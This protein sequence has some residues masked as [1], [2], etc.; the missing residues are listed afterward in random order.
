M[1]M[2]KNI[3]RSLAGSVLMLIACC[4][5]PGKGG[6]V[7]P[8]PPPPQENVFVNP[9]IRGSD[10]WVYK[11]DSMYYYMHTMGNSI[12]LWKTSE[13]S[14]L[15]NTIPVEILRPPAMETSHSRNLWAPEIHR[16][17][18][19]WYVYYTAGAGADSTQRLWVIENSDA[20]PGSGTWKD[21]GRIYATDSDFWAIDATVLHYEGAD[22]LL[23]SGR[24]DLSKQNQNLYIAKMKDPLTLELPTVMISKPE[25][26]WEL[27]GEVNEGPQVLINPAGRLFIVY[28]ASGCWTDDYA[29]GLL[30]L[31]QGGDPL[32]AGDWSKTN[33][34]VF[35]QKPENKTF[36]PGHNAFFKSADNKEDWIIYHANSNSGDGCTNKR[37]VRMQSFSWKADGTPDFGIPV[38]PG[39]SIPVPSGEED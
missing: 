31:K 17:N 25:L 5:S 16:L 1:I 37:N 2:M 32:V 3:Y 21:M 10:P 12:S 4:C 34:P 9:V 7:Q 35:V 36:G 28:S 27:N 39:A 22:Y 15:G 33:T 14:E 6:N 38:T 29:L 23:W 18:N 8:P 11:K 30:S 24:P 13:M 26:A 19:K 20:D